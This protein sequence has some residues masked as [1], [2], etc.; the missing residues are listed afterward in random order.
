VG[1]ESGWLGGRIR[2]EV[3]GYFVS[4]DVG[5]SKVAEYEVEVLLVGGFEPV[6]TGVDD[7]DMVASAF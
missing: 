6:A 4:G 3:L 2:A 5:Q 1:D 7:C